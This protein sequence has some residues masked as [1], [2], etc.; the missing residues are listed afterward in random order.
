VGG[1]QCGWGEARTCLRRERAV[2]VA[3]S[4]TQQ[5]KLFLRLT[6]PLTS[7]ALEMITGRG[8]SGERREGMQAETRRLRAHKGDREYPPLRSNTNLECTMLIISHALHPRRN[9]LTNSYVK[10]DV[11]MLGATFTVHSQSVPVLSAIVYLRT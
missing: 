4:A 3:V 11:A 7:S 5:T 2:P 1:G 9:S 10:N 6:L 8:S